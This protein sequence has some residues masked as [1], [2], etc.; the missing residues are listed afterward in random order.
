MT[1]TVSEF[2]FQMRY[3]RRNI[4]PYYV[5]DWYQAPT[6]EVVAST[7][8][9]AIRKAKTALGEA[10]GP[11]VWAFIVDKIRDIRIPTEPKE[12]S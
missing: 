12:E 8:E 1:D 6:I 2:V 4:D 11:Y 5:A 9:E 7:K 3:I 10:G